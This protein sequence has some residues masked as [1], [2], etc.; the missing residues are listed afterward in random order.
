MSSNIP[1]PEKVLNDLAC[2]IPPIHEAIEAGTQN[3]RDYFPQDVKIDPYLAAQ[4][5]RYQAKVYLQKRGHEI[6]NL[7]DLMEDI[8]NNGLILKFKKYNIRILK[9]QSGTLPT[10]GHSI[11]R[12]EYYQQ[13]FD[14]SSE[15]DEKTPEVNLI[16]LW[17]TNESFEIIKDLKLVYQKSGGFLSM[18]KL[19]LSNNAVQILEKRYL[20]K[21]KEGKVIEKPEDMFKRVAENIAFADAKYLLTEEIDALRQDKEYYEIVKTKAFETLIKKNKKDGELDE[22]HDIKNQILSMDLNDISNS[23]KV[24]TNIRGLGVAGASGLLSLIYPDYFGT[25]DQFVVKA[26][27]E[28]NDKKK[29]VSEMNPEGL[30]VKD[31]VI[32]TE[33]MKEKAS[34]NNELFASKFWNPRTL[35]MALWSYRS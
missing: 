16:I 3:A 6:E 7:G 18:V 31:G 2:I 20:R 17:E 21:D 28:V 26:L 34:E 29:M 32:L 12:Q 19:K 4:M 14:F 24:T 30:T 35:E 25:V 22:L 23:L 11:A 10:P 13:P 27:L 8:A 9:S 5:A 1:T 15:D 33:I